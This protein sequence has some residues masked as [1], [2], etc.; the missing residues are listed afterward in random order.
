MKGL[1]GAA[2]VMGSLMY[3]AGH[4]WNGTV[5]MHLRS[6]SLEDCPEDEEFLRSFD[7]NDGQT[8]PM[9]QRR[10]PPVALAECVADIMFKRHKVRRVHLV[11]V[12]LWRPWKIN[13]AQ[14]NRCCLHVFV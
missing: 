13:Q 14:V 10:Y 5:S 11:I 12:D 4:C 1:L 8:G 7:Q 9:A 3:G 2:T 6:P